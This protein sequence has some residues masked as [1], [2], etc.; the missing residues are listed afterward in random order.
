[1]RQL[2]LVREC[3]RLAVHK[4][5]SGNFEK[6]NHEKGML[7]LSI[8]GTDSRWITEKSSGSR[9]V[10]VRVLLFATAEEVGSKPNLVPE[11]VWMA[12]SYFSSVQ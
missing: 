4:W 8:S 7:N 10:G 12:F 6:N 2:E 3:C 1:M 11:M 5:A 9:S